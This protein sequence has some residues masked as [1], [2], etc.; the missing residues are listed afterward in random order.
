MIRKGADARLEIRSSQGNSS[1]NASGVS[2]TDREENQR[3]LL[4]LINGNF[5]V[6]GIHQSGQNGPASVELTAGDDGSRHLKIHDEGGA[7]L[8]TVSAARDTATTLNMRHPDHERSLQ[9][10]TG[11]SPQ[12][13]FFAPANQDGTG[14][15]LPLLQLGLRE[16]RQPFIRIADSDGSPLFTAPTE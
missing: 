15:L 12:I 10:S 4:A 16:D 14:G 11:E 5:P 3:L 13:A 6:L 8:L 7:P 2:I 1:T 9:I